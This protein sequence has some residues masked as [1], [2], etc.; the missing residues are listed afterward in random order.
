MENFNGQ[1]FSKDLILAL[2]IIGLF[3]LIIACVNFIN[4]TTAQAVNRAREVG[5]RKVLGSNRAQLIFQ[6]L[7]ETGITTLLALIG[8]VVIVFICLPF[9]ND[10]LEIHLSIS[11]LSST[12]LMLFMISALVVVTFYQA[13][14]PRWC[15]QVSNL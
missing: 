10:L 2:S 14:T 7:G 6:F 13:F 1:T 9:V 3:L 12:E 5:V 11:L 15:Y 8:S 4:L